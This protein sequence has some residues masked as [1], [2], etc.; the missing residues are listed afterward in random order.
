MPRPKAFS[1]NNGLMWGH[2]LGHIVHARA[3]HHHDPLNVQVFQG[4]EHMANERPTP[5]VMH[6]FGARRF[7]ARTQ[8]C[9]K[10]NG[11]GGAFC[12]RAE[13]GIAT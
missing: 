12:H 9:G 1:L 7:H 8:A 11:G 10:N 4:R 6:H 5:D 13:S 2:G 3:N